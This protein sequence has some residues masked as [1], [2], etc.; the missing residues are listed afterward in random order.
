MHLVCDKP[1]DRSKEEKQ[2]QTNYLELVRPV[3]TYNYFLFSLGFVHNLE[4][5][6]TYRE[7]TLNY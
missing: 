5:S 6:V 4:L 7:A 2:V 1:M 3:G